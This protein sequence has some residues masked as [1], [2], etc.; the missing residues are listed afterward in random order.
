MLL[1]HISRGSTVTPQLQQAWQVY[2]CQCMHTVAAGCGCLPS[3]AERGAPSL[4]TQM[5]SLH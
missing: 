2:S 4:C 5:Q 3:G 1:Q